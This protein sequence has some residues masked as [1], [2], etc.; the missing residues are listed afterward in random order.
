MGSELQED[1]RDKQ[2]D[3]AKDNSPRKSI[4]WGILEVDWDSNGVKQ[5]GSEER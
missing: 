3:V 4:K 1:A 2:T 5:N